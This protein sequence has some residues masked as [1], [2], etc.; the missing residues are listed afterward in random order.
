ML[1]LILSRVLLAVL[2]GP[3]ILPLPG[4]CCYLLSMFTTPVSFSVPGFLGL[5]PQLSFFWLLNDPAGEL[6][7]VVMEFPES[8]FPCPL[9]LLMMGF[10]GQV[11]NNAASVGSCWHPYA[12]Y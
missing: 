11:K 5:L 4:C 12:L 10:S 6:V 9:L 8:I 7:I 2:P 3:L 1:S